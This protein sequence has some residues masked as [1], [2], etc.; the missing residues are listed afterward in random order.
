MAGLDWSPYHDNVFVSTEAYECRQPWLDKG[1]RYTI[2]HQSS[3]W[4]DWAATWW[5]GNTGTQIG[6]SGSSAELAA[7]C[8]KHLDAM[9][10]GA[11]KA[12]GIR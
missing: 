4:V 5:H 2:V 10:A 12:S 9:T 7:M 11:M 8:K 3:P 1:A 6:S